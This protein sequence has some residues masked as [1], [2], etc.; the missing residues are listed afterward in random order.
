[1]RRATHSDEVLAKLALAALI[2][3]AFAI[4]LTA[5]TDGDVFWHLAGGREM[6]KRGALLRFD[7]F[8]L[9]AQGRPWIDVHWLF[10]LICAIGYQLG[11]LRALV[12]GKALLVASGALV[13][14]AFVRR[15]VGTAAL[16]LCV[17]GLLGALLAVR[18]L[19]LLRPT[20]FTLLF[21]ALF[22]HT[23]ELS[24][25]EGRPRRLWL[26]PLV[27][28]AWVNIQG[29]FALGPAIIVAYW[30]GLT[31][32]ARFG[33]SRFFPF[34]R[35]SLRSSED[36]L[37]E[38]LLWALAGSAIACLANPF[39]LRAVGL[40]SELLRRL[41]PGHGNAFSKEVAENVPPF[42][43]YAQTGQF[44]HLK[45]FLLALA[46]S[47]DVAG[48]RLRLHHCLLVGGF[49]LLALIANRNLLLFYWVATP[50]GVGYL[51]T[52][53]LRLL[54]R[55]RELHVALRAATGAG[56]IALS[57]LAVRTAQ[58]EPSIDA[59]APFRVPEL[60]AGWIAQH[61]G[62]SRI[63]AADHYGGYLIWKLF[64]NHAPYIDT[65]LILRTEQ[66]FGEY[67]SVVDHPERFDAFAERVHFDYVVL[68]T[69]YPERYLA[70]LRHLHESTGWQLVS[71]DGSETLFARRGL[72]NIAELNLGDAGTTAR[73]LDDI[74]RRYPDARVRAD[75][76]LQLA[77]LELAL[78][79][80]E[81]V[82]RALGESDD[83][84]ALALCARARL[85]Q[86]DS[87]GAG[88]IA[89]RAL[90]TDPDHVRS[91]NLLAV[92]SL[93][94]G[95]IGKAMGYLRHAARANPFDPET[96]TLLHSLEV[97]PHDTIN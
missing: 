4:C 61:G 48:R 67:L 5:S 47:V 94:R 55:R 46:L 42:V 56:V 51:F 1:M 16:P 6:L 49:I 81:Q 97:K 52:G 36:G 64:P 86:A 92:I 85:A 26:L 88:R 34:A 41:I 70:L 31:L 62:K 84:H 44:W 14:A 3:G 74:V 11:G 95:E 43:L 58:S 33:R 68:P 22:I 72:E 40:P 23:I 91:L 87:A 15:W 66:E 19:L 96:L 37:R 60:S 38:G 24:R 65:R 35:D 7:E 10:Q 78:G 80:P 39:G 20:M 90:Q 9:S 2:A 8:S 79:Y 83:V 12:L 75:A 13:L 63:F 28:I 25:L 21:I 89:L 54:P 45:W 73:L 30:V 29:L 59:P 77:T 93:E 82:E 50:I 27:Q 32:E 57:L 18:D 76:R 17:L 53:A 71:S 69:A